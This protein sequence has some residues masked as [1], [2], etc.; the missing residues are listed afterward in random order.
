MQSISET[1]KPLSDWHTVDLNSFMPGQSR[2]IGG[3]SLGYDGFQKLDFPRMLAKL[4][5]SPEQIQQAALLIIGRLLHPGSE[6]ET[7]V[8]GK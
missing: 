6:R 4:G 7:A 1:E 8:L 3:E 5:L 2:T